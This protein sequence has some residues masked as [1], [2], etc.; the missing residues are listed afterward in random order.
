[1][2]NK[3]K[4]RGFS[5]ETYAEVV[6]LSKLGWTRPEITAELEMSAATISYHRRKAFHNGD[7][8]RY[9]SHR[10]LLVPAPE[11]APV[12][13]PTPQPLIIRVPAG[14]RV[15]VIQDSPAADLAFAT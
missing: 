5:G 12:E 1:M 7:L 3:N 11:P 6:R 2:E 14:I 4:T 13:L 9:A 10:R 15:E 8:E